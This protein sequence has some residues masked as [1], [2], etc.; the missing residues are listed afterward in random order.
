MAD[1]AA[2]KSAA[3]GVSKASGVST[4]RP[5]IMVTKRKDPRVGAVKETPLS[6][7]NAEKRA[8]I[9]AKQA[10]EARQYQIKVNQQL[11]D[12]ELMRRW[13]E[14]GINTPAAIRKGLMR[15]I[16]IDPNTSTPP[17]EGSY[18]LPYR[19]WYRD[20]QPIMFEGETLK[21][22]MHAAGD[23]YKF[24]PHSEILQVVKPLQS[25]ARYYD[26]VGEVVNTKPLSKREPA[27]KASDINMAML[28]DGMGKLRD[29]WFEGTSVPK[30]REPLPVIPKVKP[31]ESMA[32][33]PAISDIMK[34]KRPAT[35]ITPDVERFKEDVPYLAENG[36]IYDSTISNFEQPTNDFEEMFK[37]IY[38]YEGS[39]FDPLKD[40]RGGKI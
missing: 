12:D 11:L 35:T 37:R 24:G 34:T 29:W 33:T 32:T 40:K 31:V 7:L 28:R 19:T 3:K 13:T 10:E 26:T 38:G 27:N 15:A 18:V 6:T 9:Q 39:L 36:L 30:T 20:G 17:I 23:Y 21:D 25:A 5:R 16:E 8:A 22:W 4:K 2:A 1:E 14:Q